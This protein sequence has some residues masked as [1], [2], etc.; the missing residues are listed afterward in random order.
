MCIRLSHKKELA[1]L[2]VLT[3][4]ISNHDARGNSGQSHQSGEARG[5]VLAETDPAM[6]K[7]FVEIV[8]FVFAR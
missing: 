5:I 4:Q 1:E 8:P 7:E 3:A 2:V 6:E